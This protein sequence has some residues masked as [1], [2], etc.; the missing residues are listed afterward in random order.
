MF[1]RLSLTIISTLVY[2]TLCSQQIVIQGVVTDRQSGDPIEFVTVYQNGTTNNVETNEQGFYQIQVDRQRSVELIYTRLGYEEG[3][4]NIRANRDRYNMDITLQLA[5]SEIEVTV[6]DSKVSERDMVQETTE[7]LKLLPST[8]GNLESVLPHIA[9][10]ARSGTG[11]E[12]S[13]QYN[14]RGGNYDENLVYVNDFEIFRPQLLR[15]SQQEGLS[16]PNIDLIRDLRFSSGGYEAKY[17]DKMSSVLDI[18]YK[19]P[20]D[21]K[22]SLS[23]SFLGATGH[24]EGSAAPQTGGPNKLRYL[25]GYRY[26]TNRYLLSSLDTEGEYNPNFTD[27]Q[28]YLTYDINPDFQVGVLSNYNTSTYDFRPVSRSTAVGLST[29]ALALNSVFEGRESDSFRTGMAG[30]SFT[31]L[32]EKQKNPFF[33][34]LLASTYRGLEKEAV[35]ISGFY[36]LSQIETDIDSENAGE[37]IAVLGV[38]TQQQFSRNRLF[39]R[40]N[41][42]QLRGGLELQSEENEER[43]HFIQWGGTFRNEQ[44]DDRLNEWERLDSA[45]YSLEFSEE[46]VLVENVLKSVNLINSNK[47]FGYIQDTYTSIGD[48]GQELKITVGSRFSYWDLNGEFNV[49]PRFQLLYKP[50]GEKDIS[51]KLAGGIYYQTPF[52]RELRRLD[53]TINE[54]IRAQKSIHVVAGMTSD[55]YWERMSDKPFRFIVEGYYKN[56][57]N[58]ISYDIDNVRIRYSGEN[59]ATGSAMGLDAR[60]NGEFVPGAESWFNISF[61]RV[62]ESLNGIQHQR[63]DA[64]ADAFVNVDDVARPTNQTVHFSLYFQDYLP[65]NENFKVN[66]LLTYG[67]GLP[68]GL[69]ENNTIIRNTFQFKDYRRVDLGLSLQLWNQAWKDRKPNHLLRGFDNA[70][71]SLEAFNLIGIENVS[72][73]TWVKSIFDQQFAVPNNLTNRRINLRLRVEF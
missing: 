73:N 41:S 51:Y 43:T 61:L 26:K 37:E 65:R 60:L 50:K 42:I 23:A 55:F 46:E 12:L 47:I 54:N 11:G 4:M 28:A 52:Y 22:A 66:F 13:S 20:T 53:G 36:R 14:V 38:G 68:F 69:P 49:S 70:W 62:R 15:A 24:I 19:R 35:D 32:P 30:M 18:Y 31:Y 17:G 27:V 44:F 67:T 1:T 21:R 59:D 45:G 7:A 34:K 48:E 58:L 29:A 25:L 5:D 56:L 16:F 33:L 9:L 63:Y 40:I 64:S 6:T 3:T 57:N 10:G 71:I 39:S 72:S 2:V 8:T